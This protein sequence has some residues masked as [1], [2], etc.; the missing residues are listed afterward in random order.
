MK[1][2]KVS[3]RVVEVMQQELDRVARDPNAVFWYSFV[4]ARARVQ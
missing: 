4:Q 2:G 3:A 1:A